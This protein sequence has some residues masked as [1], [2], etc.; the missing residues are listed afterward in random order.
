LK[1]EFPKKVLKRERSLKKG[2]RT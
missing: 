2:E 1:K